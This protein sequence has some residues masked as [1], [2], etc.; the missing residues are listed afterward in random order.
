VASGNASDK[1]QLRPTAASMVA[2]I[3][4]P[5]MQGEEYGAFY[6]ICCVRHHDDFSEVDELEINSR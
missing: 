2:F 6:V 3:T 4:T 5:G 1:Q